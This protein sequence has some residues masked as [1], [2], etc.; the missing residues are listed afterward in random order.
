M[1]IHI[2]GALA[3]EKIRHGPAIG[4]TGL[5][6]VYHLAPAIGQITGAIGTG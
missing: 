4:S 3:V 6:N 2:I 5:F 1:V